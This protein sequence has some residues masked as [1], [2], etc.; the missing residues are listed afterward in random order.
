MYLCVG[1]PTSLPL[2][3][4]VLVWGITHMHSTLEAVFHHINRNNLL[5]CKLVDQVLGL[6]AEICLGSSRKLCSES[7]SA[8]LAGLNNL[9]LRLTL[10][11]FLHRGEHPLQATAHLIR[12]IPI[13]GL[14]CSSQNPQQGCMGCK[15]SIDGAIC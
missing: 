8:Q 14:C 1:V 11:G 9:E 7:S 5:F 3:L 6:R 15:Q 10:L 2:T 12:L 4:Q 13:C